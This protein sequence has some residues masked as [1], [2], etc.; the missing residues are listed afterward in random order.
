[1]LFILKPL[2]FII[3]SLFHM[4]SF[5]SFKNFKFLLTK[6]LFHYFKRVFRD[7]LKCLDN[8]DFFNIL[9]DRVGSGTVKAA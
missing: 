3:Q 2:H 1:M 4:I 7:L 5:L 6:V 8:L 9:V